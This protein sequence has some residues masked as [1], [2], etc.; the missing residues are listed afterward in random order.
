MSTAE[1]RNLLDNNW[2][3][4]NIFLKPQYKYCNR[5]IKIWKF[6]DGF[7]PEFINWVN[8]EFNLNL[9]Y[10]PTNR[11]NTKFDIQS[12]KKP[13]R[14]E[15]IDFLNEKYEWDFNYFGYSYG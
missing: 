8:K 1:V 7:G 5:H 13:L 11:S 10:S 3:E 9:I 4:Q 14:P 12:K 2:N 6:E 15:V